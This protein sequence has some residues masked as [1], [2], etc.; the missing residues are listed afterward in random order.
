MNRA[1]RMHSFASGTSLAAD[2]QTVTCTPADWHDLSRVL[3][4]DSGAVAT[5]LVT[6][7]PIPVAADGE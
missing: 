3:L 7:Q 6:R 1:G 4:A 2:G 5:R